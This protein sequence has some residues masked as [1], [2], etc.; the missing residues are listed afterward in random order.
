MKNNPHPV[1]YA[2]IPPLQY[3][4]GTG[5]R[6]NKQ[7]MPITFSS[8]NR[9][10]FLA[11]SIAM[12]AMGALAACSCSKSS[13][14][15]PIIPGTD[16]HPDSEA[17]HWVFLSDTHLD[18][19]PAT[20]IDGREDAHGNRYS[21]YNQFV[22]AREEILSLPNKPKGVIITGDIALQDGKINDYQRFAA[23]IAP[24]VTAGIPVHVTMG[25]HDRFNNFTA[26][27]TEQGITPVATKKV[28]IIET[29]NSY[30]FL[31]DSNKAGGAYVEGVLGSSQL[32]WLEK[33]LDTHKD[34]PVILL[35]HHNI[36][37]DDTGGLVDR[38]ELLD[39]IKP[40][41]QVKAYL[42]GH[43]HAYRQSV[44]TGNGL[45]IVT[46]PALGYEFLNGVEPVG[47]T[48]AYLTDKGIEL[49]LHTVDKT[50]SKNNNVRKF[51]WLI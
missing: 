22:T 29:E 5:V 21:P 13:A 18:A 39:I 17:E 35:N 42:H 51:K 44:L 43:T 41:K 20:L 6:K 46:L 50:H 4:E 40:Q 3:G 28:L 38:N 15:D 48:D 34:K 37:V 12:G 23:L 1:R 10:Q 11:S 47:W 31:L 32:T 27:F 33:A 19:N 49:T 26:V 14:T 30:L 2:D 16:N 36:D 25:N 8:M 9:R 7:I 24:L 45:Q